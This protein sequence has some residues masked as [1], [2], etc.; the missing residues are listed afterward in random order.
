MNVIEEY[1]GDWYS[2]F[3]I[4]ELNKIILTLN[5]LYQ[6]KS[7]TPE[8]HDVFKA[9]NI[10]SR[11]DCKIV[12][13]GQDPYP[14][15]GVATGLL[16][17]N[18]DGKKPISPSLNIIKQARDEYFKSTKS[19][20]HSSSYSYTS[21]SY[22]R[23]YSPMDLTL[24]SWAKQG[25]LLLNT[26]LTCEVG[27]IGSHSMMWRP[28]MSKFFRNLSMNEPGLIYVFFGSQAKTFQHWIIKN[29]KSYV[30]SAE[31]PASYAR[32]DKLMPP[33]IFET[34]NNYLFGLYNREINW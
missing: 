33:D 34:V 9:F 29:R 8:Y 7:I 25:I 4:N 2:M 15:K 22:D 3:D 12:F 11:K 24:E 27:K 23:I 21:S 18:N 6:E 28:F 26:S 16:F 17:G 1:V 30:F 31:H 20:F 19:L 10:C 5:K 32:R 14:Q 13:V